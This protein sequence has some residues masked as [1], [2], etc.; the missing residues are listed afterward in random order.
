ME[1][2]DEKLDFEASIDKRLDNQSNLAQEVAAMKEKLTG[3]DQ[4]ITA[5]SKS[6]MDKAKEHEKMSEMINQFKNKLIYE[7]AF[8]MTYGAKR[9]KTGVISLKAQYEEVTINFL[10]DRSFEE[11]FFLVIES[12]DF[13]P[14]TGCKDKRLI[15]VDDVDEIEHTGGLQFILHYHDFSV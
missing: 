10:R 14:K 3:K 4:A 1:L 2:K 12:K 9:L 15:A 13:N 11:E 6:L 7:N 5:L 8:H